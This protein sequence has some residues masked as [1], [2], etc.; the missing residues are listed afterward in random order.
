MS[1]PSRYLAVAATTA[2]LLVA[3][4]VAAN[5]VVDPFGMTRAVVRAGFNA[6]KPAIH[7]R[8]RLAKAYDLRHL[9]P[10][11][12]IL[13][14]SR[15]HVGLRP[16]HPGFAA[17]PVYNLSFDGA[18]TRELHAYLVHAQS[19]RPLARAVLA[20]D[21]WHLSNL[22]SVVRPSFDAGVLLHGGGVLDR[23]RLLASDLRVLASLDTLR[24]S[25][26]TLGAQDWAEPEWLAPDGQRRGELFFRRPG[27]MFHDASPRAYFEAND[28]EEIGWRRPAPGAPA[29]RAPESPPDPGETSLAYVRRIVD[30]CRAAGIDLRIL[31]T[32]A[33]ARQLEI[34]AAAGEWDGIE[35]AKRAL[36]A[37]LADDAARHSGRPPIPLWDFSGY[38]SVTAEPL[39]PPGSRAEMR[40]YWDSSHF[41]E[42]VGDWVLDRVFGTSAAAEPPPPDFGVRLTPDTI[43][44][45]LAGIRSARDAYR[46]RNEAEVRALDE[47]VAQL[48]G[49]QPR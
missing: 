17:A 19:V 43:E 35:A 21:T 15:S 47:L 42:A 39:P 26:E 3:A 10:R 2:A 28:R 18:T 13:G 22:P 30:L 31:V 27:E 20:L 6:R 25:R 32:P 49:P 14:T 44:G 41:K 48:L 45:A 16:S 11:T 5:A 12:I 40:F 38:S 9:A 7:Q 34:A 33:H 37:S 36:V 46:R 1:R 24:A 4:V 23:A 8:V 29:P